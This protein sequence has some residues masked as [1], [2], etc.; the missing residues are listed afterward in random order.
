MKTWKTYLIVAIIAFLAGAFFQHWF[1]K[2]VWP[3]RHSTYTWIYT[4][5]NHR[6]PGEPVKTD[7]VLDRKGYSVGYSYEHKAALWV[8]YI[9]SKGSIEVD[10][11]KRSSFYA[12]PDIPEEYQVQPEDHI[13]T[14]YDRGHLAPSA[15]I[16]YSRAANKETYALSNVLL[17][18][19][20]LNRQAWST[21]EKRARSWT[22]RMGK[23]YV[24]TGPVFPSRPK[25]I[26][27]MSLPSQLYKVIYAYD[28]E[29]AIGF[30]FP[31]KSVS[32]DD[33]WKYALSVEKLEDNTSLTFFSN[34][35]QR[36]QKR[37]KDNVDID[38]W[39]SE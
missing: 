1:M 20:T 22:E 25:K 26:H 37:I 35:R 14:G 16:A 39:K 34:F 11:D 31:N 5:R 3:K 19:S 13:K 2:A 10:L 33:L 18:D 32:N 36:D 17:Q 24:V 21:L 38:W 8:S 6:K 30:L 28:A 27:G 7:L 4:F 15:T 23:L 12:D 29:Q 9:F